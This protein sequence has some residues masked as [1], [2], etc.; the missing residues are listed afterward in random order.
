[1][2]NQVSDTGPGVPAGLTVF[3]NRHYK[4]SLLEYIHVMIIYLHVKILFWIMIFMIHD[5]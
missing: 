5:Q 2:N 1:M 4:S 3:E